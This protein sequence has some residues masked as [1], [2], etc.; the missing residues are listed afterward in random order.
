ANLIAD[1]S[2]TQQQYE[3]ALAAKQLA[4]NRLDILESQRQA[5]VRQVN[6]ASR[7]KSV[8]S[9]QANAAHAL[10]KQREAEVDAARLNLSYTVIKAAI[11]G[12]V[13]KV[14]L[15]PGQFLAA[16]QSLFHIVPTTDKWIVANFKET[17]L[18]R[19]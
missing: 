14:N 10:I 3:Q 6:T 18:T 19:M 9:S 17:Q 5:A 1:H 13:G 16:G 2:I 7:Q 8:N 12:Q 15:Q 4:E 11:D